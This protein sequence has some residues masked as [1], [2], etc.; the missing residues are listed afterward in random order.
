MPRSTMT[1]RSYCAASAKAASSSRALCAFEIPTEEP[2]LA[3]LTNIGNG[4]R[5][6]GR[7]RPARRRGQ[8]HVV[9][10]RQHPFLADTFHHLLVHGDGRRPARP[11]RRRAGRPVPAGPAPCRP[12]RT[13]RAA[14]ERPRRY[15]GCAPG[16]GR[17]G[18]GLHL[19]SLSIK[20]SIFSYLAGS[21]AS[22]MARAERT[23]TS[24]SPLRPP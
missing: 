23:E 11:R 2:R 8:R 1:L 17:I 15:P 9:Y 18:L 10:H 12:R 22:M 7:H 16:S 19:P 6:A 21:S 5:G 24:C 13:C 20:Y 3:G 4:R 14:P